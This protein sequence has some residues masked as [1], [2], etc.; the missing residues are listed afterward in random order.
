MSV[1]I[2]DSG[3]RR[4]TKTGA[5]RDK[6]AGKGRPSL[7]LWPMIEELSKILEGG[8]FKYEAYNYEKGLPL[9]WF[10]DS[11]IRHIFK[12]LAG[13]RDE[14]HLPMAIFGLGAVIDIK[15]RIDAGLLPKELNDLRPE[16]S[17]EDVEKLIA[18]AKLTEMDYSKMIKPEKKNEA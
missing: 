11:I 4:V 10:F 14:N 1:T 9:S 15:R 16:L 13:W 8:E 17:N 12:H 3:E 7:I 18:I 6:G 2:K 5:Q